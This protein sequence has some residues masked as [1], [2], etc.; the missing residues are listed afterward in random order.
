L[1]PT[2]ASAQ[3]VASAPPVLESEEPFTHK[4]PALSPHWAFIRGGFDSGATRI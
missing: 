2:A 1:L 4:L 3:A